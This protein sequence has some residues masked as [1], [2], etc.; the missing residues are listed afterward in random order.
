MAPE[1]TV[2]ARRVRIARPVGVRVVVAMVRRPP[3]R[4][5]LHG[6][7]PSTR[8]RLHR[9]RGAECAVREIAVIER[10][11]R[12]T[13]A[14]RRAPT[15]TATAKRLHRSTARRGSPGASRRTAR[16]GASRCCAG[17]R[18]PSRRRRVVEPAAS[19]GERRAHGVP[20]LATPASAAAPAQL[21][22]RRSPCARRVGEPLVVGVAD[23]RRARHDPDVVALL[24]RDHGLRVVR[25][26]GRRCGSR[27]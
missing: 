1:K 18:P 15:A 2:L 20:L 16:R 6:R 4:P 27:P 25:R 21:R 23:R 3:Q 13:C 9:A 7:A 17:L 22:R 14:A 5:A 19:T 26:T 12:R 10:R 11:D 24:A 8:T